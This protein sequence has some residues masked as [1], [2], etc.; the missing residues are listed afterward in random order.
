MG[1]VSAFLRNRHVPLA[2]TETP[3]AEARLEP[4]IVPPLP[5]EPTPTAA[6]TTHTCRHCGSNKVAVVYGRYSY[7]FKCSSC[8][9]NTPIK[10][11]CES[12]GQ[13]AKI[14]KERENFYAECASCERSRIFF[15]AA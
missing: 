2:G 7:Y 8:D 6:N 11:S 12:C 13:K 14:R 10:Q 3:R 4:A 5:K 15:R 1:R 9:G